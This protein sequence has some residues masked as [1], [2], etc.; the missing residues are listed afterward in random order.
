MSVNTNTMDIIEFREVMQN[1]LQINDLSCAMQGKVS[2][3]DVMSGSS[4]CSSRSS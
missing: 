2:E 1:A 3:F 4:T